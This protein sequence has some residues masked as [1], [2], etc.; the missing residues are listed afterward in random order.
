MNR[1]DQLLNFLKEDPNDPFTLYA[2]ATEYLNIDLYEARKYFEILLNKFPEYLATYY[3]AGKVY[4]ELNERELALHTYEKGI[5][6]AKKK[7]ESLAL[8]ELTNAY[9]E[10]LLD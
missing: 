9:Q 7:N 1:L 6:L 5:N 8:R 2:I 3:H 4:E 10:F